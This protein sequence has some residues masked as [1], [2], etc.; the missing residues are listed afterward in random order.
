VSGYTEW[1]LSAPVLKIDS[2]TVEPSVLATS[3]GFRKSI[4]E[5]A[6]TSK[7]PS[8]APRTAQSSLV[9]L[10]VVVGAVVVMLGR[11]M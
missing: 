3:N 11:A 6:G 2:A 5:L 10:S 4:H 9:A 1:N 8:A 7:P